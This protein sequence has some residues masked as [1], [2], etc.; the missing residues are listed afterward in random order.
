MALMFSARLSYA[1]T[2]PA[3]DR[4]APGPHRGHRGQGLRAAAAPRACA[5]PEHRRSRRCARPSSARSASTACPTAT[6]RS[7]AALERRLPSW[8]W[9]T[10]RARRAR[11]SSAS[12]T[13][14]ARALARRPPHAR[15]ATSTVA[16]DRRPPARRPLRATGSPARERIADG[17]Y[18]VSARA[19]RGLLRG[20]DG[21]AGC[22]S[23]RPSRSA[24][25]TAGAARRRGA[26]ARLAPAPDRAAVL[27]RP[28]RA[29]RDARRSARRGSTCRATSSIVGFD[30]VPEAARAATS[31]RSASR[32][33]RRAARPAGSCWS[34]T[35]SAR[36]IAAGRARVA[37]RL[38]PPRPTEA[39]LRDELSGPR[40]T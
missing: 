6:P 34:R 25:S 24:S 11:S 1:V 27:D 13:A 39:L 20:A 23:T 18:R 32:C 33:W 22:P 9:S 17:Y 35:R 7:S 19:D 28:A 3:R 26:A 2:D 10:S 36:S 4:P 21:R 15:S 37:A 30:D 14:R 40:S 38:H 31:R 5:A 8:S 12:R 29:R 16:V